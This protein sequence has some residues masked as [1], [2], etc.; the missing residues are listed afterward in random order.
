M[1]ISP[2]ETI[3]IVE[4]ERAVARGL[5]Y[6]LRA[7][8]FA[9]LW[10]ENGRLALELVQNQQPH[11][12]LLDLRLPDITGFDVCRYLRRVVTASRS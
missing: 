12:I 11:L 10:A 2:Q 3:L 7:E 1:R 5:E 6:G 8:G 4:D 9:V